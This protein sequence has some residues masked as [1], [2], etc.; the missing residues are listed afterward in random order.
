MQ[1]ENDNDQNLKILIDCGLMQ[2]TAV[3]D[4]FNRD[5]FPYKPEEIDFLI[6][7][8][9][10][11]DHIGR[12]PKLVKDGFV[13]RIISTAPTKDMANVIQDANK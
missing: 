7:T 6:V 10:H 13:G 8:H 5:P 11:M 4:S 12:I 2:G 3:S 1:S 9:A